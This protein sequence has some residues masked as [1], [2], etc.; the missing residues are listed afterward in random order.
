[1][2]LSGALASA[3]SGLT[4]ASRGAGVV[5][6]N[7]ANAQTDGYGRRGLELASAADGGQGVRIVSVERHVDKAL[8]D[9]L[10]QSSGALA[11][12]ATQ[13][14]FLDR[15]AEAQGL[16][17]DGTSLSDALS[18]LEGSLVEASSRPESD[19]RLTA[20]VS[21]AD[22]LVEKIGRI[23]KTIQ[24]ER[25]R[26]DAA[27]AADVETLNSALQRLDELN[28]DIARYKGD[29]DLAVGLLDE[30][31]RLVD[32]V[33]QIVPV[34]EFPRS[35]DQIALI[36]TGGALLLDGTAAEIGFTAS[37][38][39][40]P[41]QTYSASTLSGLTFNGQPVDLNRSNHGLSGGRLAG[42]LAIRDTLGVAA[43]ADLDAFSRDLIERFASPTADPTLTPGD[44]GLFT[45]A[46]FAL[47]PVNET[48]LS[49]RLA[50]NTLVDP[51]GSAETWRIRDGLG[52]AAP[53]DVGQAAGLILL[54]N[55]LTDTRTVMS[56]SM[57]GRVLSAPDLLFESLAHADQQLARV[58]TRQSNV[59]ARTDA[60]TLKLQRD[61]VDTDQ[62]MQR[63]LMIEQA[64]AANAQV[65]QSVETM[66]DRLMEAI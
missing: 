48:G 19:G 14:G 10:R 56:G 36:T 60:L 6:A 3:V 27:I 32:Q 54:G 26:A 40:T 5:A 38:V 49:A 4:A 11:E 57:A 63:L 55:A 18:E 7:V 24:S 37:P 12:H 21:A 61:G 33:A 22:E 2:S 25:A 1:M 45:D 58:E 47:N 52:A 51:D 20:V 28:G 39:V 43:Q 31:Q 66:L 8:L 59:M 41:Y 13:A 16:A 44:A 53:G 30:R 34:R 46:G 42:N 15:L 17:G 9:D 23:S 29:R 65:I 64:Y 62:E 35:N 50:L